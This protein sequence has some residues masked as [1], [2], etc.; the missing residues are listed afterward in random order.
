[1]N[2]IPTFNTNTYYIYNIII[3]IVIY[4]T[5][6]FIYFTLSKMI[7]FTL[8]FEN[9]L[10]VSNFIFNFYLLNVLELLTHIDIKFSFQQFNSIY[11]N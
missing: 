11:N 9:N 1:M 6:I 8:S 10:S 5:Y 7:F 2:F 4:Y 3:I